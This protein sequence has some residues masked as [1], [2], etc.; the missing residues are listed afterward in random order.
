M[1]IKLAV[2]TD[3]I[4]DDPDKACELLVSKKITGVCLRRGWCRDIYDMP[5]NAIS[6][7]GD[8]LSKHSLLPVLL[9]TEIGCVDPSQLVAEEPKLV[10][11]L[12]ICKYLKC[13][14]IRIG[15]GT[16][17][18]PTA[19]ISS[20][21][22]ITPKFSPSLDSELVQKWLT[23]ASGLSI[24]YDVQL[25]FEPETNSYYNQAAAIA[26]LLNRFRRLNLLFDPAMLVVRTKANPFVKFWSLLKS[27]TTFI[28]IHDFKTGDAAKPAGFGDAQLDV[29]VADALMS[30]FSGWFCLE[31]GLGRRYGDAT[32]KDKTFLRALDAFEALLQRIQLPKIL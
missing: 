12:Q 6:I 14:S 21:S 9:H 19:E 3:E 31:P 13:K 17:S 18:K 26:I 23:A 7:L 5:D 1:S 24:S 10:R 8:I 16:S 29:L 22:Q 28:D 2:Y 25:L 15:L 30:N 11:A 32:T 4:F 20:I 27:R